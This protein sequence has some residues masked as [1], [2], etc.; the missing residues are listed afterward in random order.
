METTTINISKGITKIFT[1]GLGSV[2]SKYKIGDLL[3]AIGNAHT[4]EM[5]GT[6]SPSKLK[7]LESVIF[8]AGFAIDIVVYNENAGFE[9]EHSSVVN[10]RIKYM[11]NAQS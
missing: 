6:V 7:R 8:A 3:K 11:L 10:F 2:V 4:F 5:T 9:G 1:S